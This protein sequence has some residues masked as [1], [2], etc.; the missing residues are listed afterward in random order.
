[1]RLA[2]S[3]A[4]LALALTAADAFADTRISR[5]RI[6]AEEG[7]R[8]TP[9]VEGLVFPW[10]MTWLPDGAIVVTEREGRVRVIRDGVLSP[11]P[12]AF[13]TAVTSGGDGGITRGQGG[14][15]D[16]A[17]S[18]SFAKD[19]TLYFTYAEGDPK[20]NRT[21]VA[22][23]KLDGAG[24]GKLTTIFANPDFKERGQHFGSRL[25]FLPD[26]AL[27]VS[28]G[29]GGNPPIE[30]QGAHIRQ[31]AQ[32]PA[33]VFGKVLRLD[34]DGKPRAGNPFAAVSGARAE[35]WTFGHRNIQGIARDSA[36][37]KIWASEHGAAGGDELNLLE[38]GGNY[39][40]PAVTFAR[41]YANGALISDK[42]RAPD[43]RDPE[44]VWLDTHAPSG[45]LVYRGDKL[46]RVNG[47][48]LSGGLISQD[49]RVVRPQ[50][51]QRARETR[52]PV[53]ER[54]RDVRVG[55]DGFVYVLT[56]GEKG[57]LLR[58]EPAGG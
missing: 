22:R 44:L 7:L 38:A 18:P 15:M 24:L 57:R 25:L 31:Q 52:I 27:L 11:A 39:G 32:S 20:A 56:D 12:I 33:S 1:M 54:V 13:P 29:D 5:G 51:G 17:A 45:L 23:A 16:V 49:V 35:I 58:L 30:F 10:G 48:I 8:L 2:V 3:F 43:M 4:A 37:G 19:R 55:P 42:T 9:V 46:A 34:P 50:E 21:I 47:A 36:T 14:L 26:G 40:W 6:A 41:E 53:G 28:I